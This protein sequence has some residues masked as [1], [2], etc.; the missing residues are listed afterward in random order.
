MMFHIMSSEKCKLK[1]PWDITTYVFEWP[2]SSPLT[3][4]NAEG[5][6][7]QEP[8]SLLVGMQN[9]AVILEDSLVSFCKTKYIFII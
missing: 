6:K 3:T 9:E 7:Q 5:V 4:P 1:Q 8:Y 2:K